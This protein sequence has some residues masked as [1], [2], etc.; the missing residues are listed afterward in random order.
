M[1]NRIQCCFRFHTRW[2]NNNIK[3]SAADMNNLTGSYGKFYPDLGLVI[4]SDRNLQLSQLGSVDGSGTLPENS[5]FDNTFGVS[6]PM[7]I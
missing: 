7:L 3:F 2:F 4:L 6:G 5:G 1:S